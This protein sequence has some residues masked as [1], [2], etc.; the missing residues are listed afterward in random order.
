MSVSLDIGSEDGAQILRAVLGTLNAPVACWLGTVA[1]TPCVLH[2][3]S[4]GLSQRNR[5]KAGQR[6][7]E[8]G[9]DGFDR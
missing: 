7:C 6:Q 3:Q 2:G 5:A 1:R 4:G 9:G 8:R